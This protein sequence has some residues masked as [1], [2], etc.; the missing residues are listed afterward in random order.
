MSAP[1]I[2]WTGISDKEYTYYIYPIDT[3]NPKSDGGNYLFAMETKPG[4]YKPV[5]VGQTNDLKERLGDHEKETCAR[6]NG[7][8]HIHAH[9]NGNK[10]SRLDEEKDIIKRW[11]PVCNDQL[12]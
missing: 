7:A 6:R 3:F 1:T 5:Y 2:K 12:A 4:S 9:L 10:Q 8:T 11:K